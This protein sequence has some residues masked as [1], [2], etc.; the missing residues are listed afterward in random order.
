[1]HEAM[2]KE[3]PFCAPEPMTGEEPLFLLY[4]IRAP[5][6]MGSCLFV[7]AGWVSWSEGQKVRVGAKS[8][9]IHCLYMLMQVSY[10]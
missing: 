1:M 8:S 6:P 10:H 5:A 7:P 3:R 9:L 4:V 2:A